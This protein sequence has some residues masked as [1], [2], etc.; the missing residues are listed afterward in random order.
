MENST[1]I[2]DKDFF[3][4]FNPASS[5]MAREVPHHLN[6]IITSVLAGRN[7]TSVTLM[8][9]LNDAIKD[10]RPL[11]VIQKLMSMHGEGNLNQRDKCG[12]TA[13]H[14]ACRFMSDN[15][16]LVQMLLEN[17]PDAVHMPDQFN[18]FPLHLACDSETSIKVIKLLL[19]AAGEIVLEPTVHLEVSPNKSMMAFFVDI[20][21]I[22]DRFSRFWTRLFWHR[23]CLFI[24]RA[25]K[26][27]QE[28]L[29][30]LYW[31]QTKMAKVFVE[32]HILGGVLS[33]LRSRVNWTM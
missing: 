29:F 33:T 21:F 14:Y 7:S 3:K 19:E 9:I 4:K 1:K 15:D 10:Q 27:C 8:E 2:K 20:L 17:S 25:R 31:M 28:R 30:L 16:S 13:L 32:R 11:E 24:W 5:Y 26:A 6:Q 22:I 12:W 18:R 23:D